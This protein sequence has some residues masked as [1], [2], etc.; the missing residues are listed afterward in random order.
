MKAVD[1]LAALPALLWPL[2]LGQVVVQLGVGGKAAATAGA[3]LLDL[4]YRMKR[5]LNRFFERCKIPFA[6]VRHV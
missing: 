4:A 6:G 1:G 3:V 2:V 5:K